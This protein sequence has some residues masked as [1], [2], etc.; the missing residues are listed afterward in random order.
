MGRTQSLPSVPTSRSTDLVRKIARRRG[1]RP[2]GRVIERIRF[3][4]FRRR[5][6]AALS[7]EDAVPV[8]SGGRWWIA[9]LE[10]GITEE[11]A[12]DFNLDLVLEILTSAGIPYFAIPDEG[13]HR[14]RVGLP[15]VHW[16]VFVDRVSELSSTEPVYIGLAA[17]NADSRTV[18]WSVSPSDATAR[19]AAMRQDYIEVFRIYTPGPGVRILGRGFGCRVERWATSEDGV[20]T[21]PVRNPRTTVIDAHNQAETY[22]T[23]HGRKLRTYAPLGKRNVFEVSEDIDLVYMWVDGSDPAWLDR[24]NRTLALKTGVVP[25]GSDTSRFRDNGELRYSMRSVH[26]FAPWSRRIFLVTDRQVPSW[27]DVEHPS[28]RVVDHS[29]LFGG[30]GELPTFNSHAIGSRLHRIPGLSDTYIIFNDDVFLGRTVSPS[31]FFRSNGVSKFF[32]SRS[33][34]P[35]VRESEEL[36]HE[37]ARR[38]AVALLEEHFG[39]TVSRTFYH[40]PIPQ[41]KRIILELEERF[42]HVFLHNW[43]SQ[44]RSPRDFEVNG[45]LHHYFGYVKGLAEPGSIRYDYFDLADVSVRPRMRKLFSRRDLDC[46]CINDNPLAR[47][48]NHSFIGDW[49]PAYYPIA[50]P[51]EL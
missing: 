9:R 44:F 31:L 45:W 3:A 27:L 34:L 36:P 25:D 15:D 33:T 12:A 7:A 17:V 51:W 32:L 49:L 2:V 30:D 47:E 29:E 41:R 6:S 14:I 1:L 20:L 43:A 23:H 24:K 42:P 28:I 18:R 50:A 37:G 38:N 10:S 40:T 48:D 16:Q 13:R 4:T 35:Y 19:S 5:N 11:D 21:A 26:Q 46:F 8:R 22:L 39:V